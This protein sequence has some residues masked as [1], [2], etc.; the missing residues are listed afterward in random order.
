MA[1]K[2]VVIESPYGSRS[3]TVRKAHKMYANHMIRAALS[4]GCIP[5]ASHVFFTEALDDTHPAERALGILAGLRLGDFADECW[6]CADLGVSAGMAEGIRR[7]QE[8]GQEIRHV[9]ANISCS[10]LLNE[11]LLPRTLLVATITGAVALL[12]MLLHH[13]A[14]AALVVGFG[15][16]ADGVNRLHVHLTAQGEMNMRAKI[17]EES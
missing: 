14:A 4:E 7:A 10:T 16:L 2:I 11:V 15:A 12:M 9:E 17:D 13:G 8:R 6:V 1:E 5:V 3:P